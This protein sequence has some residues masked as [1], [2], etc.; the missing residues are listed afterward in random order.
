MVY[1]VSLSTPAETDAYAA[2]ERIRVKSRDGMPLLNWS[3]SALA[4]LQYEGQREEMTRLFDAYFRVAGEKSLE[5]R[6][7]TILHLDLPTE[8]KPVSVVPHV[9]VTSPKLR[10]K[11][12]TPLGRP[13]KLRPTPTAPLRQTQT[14]RYHFYAKFTK[15]SGWVVQA[16][17]KLE[18]RVMSKAARL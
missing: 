4:A 18:H 15:Y 2:F 6:T 11:P 13:D 1:R 17:L 14:D 3:P 12:A 10:P 16:A 7:G 9:G 8:R 5:T